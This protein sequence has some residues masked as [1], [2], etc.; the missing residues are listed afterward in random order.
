MV[1][2]NKDFEQAKE[3]IELQRQADIEVETL[4]HQN[5]MREIEAVSNSKEKEYAPAGSNDRKVFKIKNP[6]APPTDEQ[7]AY[8]SK[9]GGNTNDL[10]PKI[11]KGEMSK[12]IDNLKNKKTGDYSESYL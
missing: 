10:N 1:K 11:T 8:F 9:I 5:K 12:L 7:I 4:R 3:L 2:Q 6:E